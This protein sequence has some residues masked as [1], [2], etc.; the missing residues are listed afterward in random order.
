MTKKWLG[1]QPET[2]ELCLHPLETGDTFYDARGHDTR[3]CLMCAGCFRRLGRKL[4]TGLGQQYVKQAPGVKK[5]DSISKEDF[6]KWMKELNHWLSL[7]VGLSASDLPYI[8]FWSLFEDG[9]SPKS[10][11]VAVLEEAGYPLDMIDS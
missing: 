11:A 3:W 10:G 4:G 5:D 7:H 6:D 9:E 8:D 2:C 1:T